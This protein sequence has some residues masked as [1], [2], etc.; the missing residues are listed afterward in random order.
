MTSFVCPVCGY[1]ELDEAPRSVRGGGSSEICPSC[2]FEFGW[3]DEAQ[4]YDYAMWR[5]KWV[6]EGMAWSDAAQP[7]DDGWDPAAQLAVL[8]A[9]DVAVVGYWCPVCGYHGL[10]QPPMRLVDGSGVTCPSCGFVYGA[11]SE[12]IIIPGLAWRAAWIERGMPWSDGSVSPP[13]NWDPVAQL[14]EAHDEQDWLRLQN[15]NPGE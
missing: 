8:A 7:P 11:G 3:T 9:S 6:A 10:T 14:R 1:P 2:G 4:G 5:A 13:E 12:R 15:S